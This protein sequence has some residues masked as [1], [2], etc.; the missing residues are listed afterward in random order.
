MKKQPMKDK[1]QRFLFEDIDIRGEIVQLDN[2][3]L[4]I[5]SNHDY[6]SI[7]ENYL[8]EM[9][10][11]T[12]LLAATLKIDGSLS[13]QAS[14]NGILNLLITECRNN[15]TIRAIAKYQQQQLTER[16]SNNQETID[17]K[18]LLGNGSL[19]ITIEQKNGQRYQGIVAIEGNSIATMLEKHL[20]Q[21]EQLKTRIVLAC[22]PQQQGNPQT[23]GLLLQE[24]P[25]QN[26]E[27]QQ[28]WNEV[29]LLA[30]TLT[31]DELLSQSSEKMIHLLF[32]EYDIRQFPAE[33]VS[34]ECTC[35]QQKVSNMLLSLD[36]KEA[37]EIIH[38]SEFIEVACEF[39]H[40]LY[41]FDEL[42]INKIFSKTHKPTLH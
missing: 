32:N 35:S 10:A 13:I 30:E 25:H 23:A 21:S 41:R 26:E 4:D 16:L 15:L 12:V 27:H 9:M 14:G 18:D 1:L 34:F 24:L 42:D 40:H 6:P 8:G 36:Y 39:C 31:P 19:I 3:W 38:Q 5:L 11:A 17:L 37:Q 22:T 20:L 33:E 2:S 29:S 28:Q 7:I